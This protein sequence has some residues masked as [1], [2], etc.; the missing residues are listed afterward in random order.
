MPVCYASYIGVPLRAPKSYEKILYGKGL[1]L[2]F[3]SIS[4]LRARRVA[5]LVSIFVSNS[6]SRGAARLLAS[7]TFL[8][9]TQ[10]DGAPLTS[11]SQQFSPQPKK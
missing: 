5:T 6:R 10:L 11:S 4:A 2:D 9:I 3:S 1:S 7:Q 8:E